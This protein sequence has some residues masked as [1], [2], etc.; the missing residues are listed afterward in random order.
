MDN[1]EVTDAEV[2][3]LLK[4]DGGND[5]G[6]WGRYAEEHGVYQRE[7]PL[8]RASWQPMPAAVQAHEDTWASGWSGSGGG[9]SGSLT[10]QF[11]PFMGLF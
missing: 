8:D 4:S 11:E 6:C 2:A 10:G 7:S 5:P 1:D 3:E 9:Y